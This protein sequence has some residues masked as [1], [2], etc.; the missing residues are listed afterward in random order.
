M[1][2][3]HEQARMYIQVCKD[4]ANTDDVVAEVDRYL[5]NADLTLTSLLNYPR[6][7]AAFLKCNAP[8]PSSAAVVWTRPI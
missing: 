3:D 5:S 7:A 1:H 4:S 6:L 8:L 2:H